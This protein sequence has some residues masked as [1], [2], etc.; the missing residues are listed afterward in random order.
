MKLLYLRLLSGLNGPL[1]VHKVGTLGSYG[2]V[3]LAVHLIELRQKDHSI[4]VL[5]APHFVRLQ[6]HLLE[7]AEHFLH[8]FVHFIDLVIVSHHWVIIL[9]VLFVQRQP[10]GNRVGIG[11]GQTLQFDRNAV[12]YSVDF[13]K[14]IF[15]W[16][17]VLVQ[18]V[19]VGVFMLCCRL[20]LLLVQ[21]NLLLSLVVG[22]R[23][24]IDTEICRHLH[25]LYFQVLTFL[26][27]LV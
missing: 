3:K 11:E 23:I 2:R 20:D 13:V 26:V 25:L 7:I 27:L 10:I 22:R 9:S 18:V 15:Q 14:M 4:R 6:L 1:L 8:S 19:L 24:Q 16:L 21:L 5:V 17:L 12:E